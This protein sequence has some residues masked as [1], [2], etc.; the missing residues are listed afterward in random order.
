MRSSVSPERD[1]EEFSCPNADQPL[2]YILVPQFLRSSRRLALSPLLRAAMD[3]L[4]CETGHTPN[5]HSPRELEA[6]AAN[7]DRAGRTDTSLDPKC[8]MRLRSL[9]VMS[10]GDCLRL[11]PLVRV[12]NEPVM[13]SSTQDCGCLLLLCAWDPP[14]QSKPAMLL[15]HVPKPL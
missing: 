3:S 2:R 12:I 1:V 6:V 7:V 9:H 8:E 10:E 15:L 14:F 13:T 4:L 5:V 11:G